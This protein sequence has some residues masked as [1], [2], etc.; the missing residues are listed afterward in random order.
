M[1]ATAGELAA[2]G[3]KHRRVSL[4]LWIV[5]C[6]RHRDRH[7]VRQRVQNYQKCTLPAGMWGWGS[8]AARGV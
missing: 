5:T 8:G 6:V 3:G 7:Y 4:A 1:S 2:T